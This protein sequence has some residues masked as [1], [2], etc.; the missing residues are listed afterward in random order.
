MIHYLSAP[1][2]EPTLILVPCSV[3]TFQLVKD[4]KHFE[5]EALFAT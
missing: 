3:P 4:T 1:K 2:N 5:N